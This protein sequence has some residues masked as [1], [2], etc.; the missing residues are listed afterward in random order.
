MEA[1]EAEEAPRNPAARVERLTG[2]TD[3]KGPVEALKVLKVVW[4]PEASVYDRSVEALP[5]ASIYQAF[6]WGEIRRAQGLVPHRILVQGGNGEPLAAATW[7][8]RPLPFGR[9]VLIGARGPLWAPAHPEAVV[10]LIEETSAL[11]RECRALSCRLNPAAPASPEGIRFLRDL[12]L[13]TVL[14]RHLPFGGTLPVREW[15][16]ALDG[17][18]D[19]I[20]QGLNPDHRRLVRRAH[21]RG[22]VVTEGTPGDLPILW[23]A[24]RSL[25]RRKGL[26]MRSER[27]LTEMARIWMECGEGLFLL[28]QR[29]GRVLGASL[30]T[31]FGPEALGH[32][33]ADDGSSRADGV[34][35][36]LYWAFLSWAHRLGAKVANLGGV[37]AHPGRPGSLAGLETFKRHFGGR[38]VTYVGEWDAV[39]DPGAYRMLRALERLVVD[40]GLVPRLALPAMEIRGRID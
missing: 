18:L 25:A 9:S 7:V 4:D 17:T 29:K 27:A 1:G 34:V 13:R 21:R 10:R 22:I 33:M 38:P 35:H 23:K 30:S 36:A 39:F 24:V 32:F 14:W 5:H 26:P 11:A 2:L 8:E 40:E 12:G 28:A 15:H 16:L 20:W 31:R 37:A 3:G 6:S 19:R